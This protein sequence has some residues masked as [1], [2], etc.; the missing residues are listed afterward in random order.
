MV[1]H[2]QTFEGNIGHSW[3]W[4]PIRRKGIKTIH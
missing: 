4:A 1:A 3:F 2:V